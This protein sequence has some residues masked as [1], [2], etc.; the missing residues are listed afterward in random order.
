LL[1]PVLSSYLDLVI[2]I[3]AVYRLIIL[4]QKRDFCLLAALGT[5][6]GIHLARAA[7]P[8]ASSTIPEALSSFCRATRRAA[9][10]FIG[11]A[12]GSEELLLFNREGECL[13]AIGTSEG[14]F[15]VSH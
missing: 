12:F 13:S 11:E 3:Q 6:C 9:L 2:A 1:E 15:C 4:R 10:W 14:F 8:V 5:G 7:I